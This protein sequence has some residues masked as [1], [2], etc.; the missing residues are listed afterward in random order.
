MP[1]TQ[2]ISKSKLLNVLERVIDEIDDWLIIGDAEGKIVYAN[3]NV[4]TSCGCT[5]T[6]ILGQD[7][8]MF[9]GVDLADDTVL[10]KIRK[11]VME[12]EKF[13]FVTNRFI[14]NEKRIYLTNSFNAVWSEKKLEYYVCI[15]KDI[16]RTQRMKEEVY[17]VSYIDYLTNFP[18][19][20]VFLESLHKQVQRSRKNSY[21]FTVIL[22]DIKKIGEIN[23]TYG[24]GVGDKIIKEVG[25]RIKS[26][27]N[28]DQEIFKYTD[29]TFAVIHQN[30]KD[31]E[32]TKK[33]LET[34]NEVMQ[35][36]I[37]IH[38]SYMYMA[39]KAGVVLYPEN[40]TSPGE[41]VKMVQIALAKA[42][43]EISYSSYVFYTKDIQEE[44][45]NNMLLESDMR[46]AVENDEFLVYYQPF[47]DLNSN[48]IVGM[49]ALI[50]RLMGNGELVLPGKFIGLLEKMNLIEKVGIMVIEKVCVQIRK[51]IDRGYEIVPISVNLSALQ[52][53]NP[54]LAKNIKN[55]LNRYEIE[56]QYI[57]LEIT[58]STVMEDVGIAQLVIHELKSYGFTISIDDF[59]TGYASIG[60]LK[61]FMFDHLKIDISFIRE[62]VK[63]PQDRTIVEAII[64][65]AKTLNLKTIA[66]GIENEEQLH[67]MSRLGCE[68]GQGFLWNKPISAV[69]I[70]D[71]YFKV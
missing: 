56:P 61:K 12:G 47:V 33:L 8:C 64:S 37:K 3:E 53:K 50:R 1:I 60:Y 43:K 68:M 22:I 15:S 46:I 19:E 40:S 67:I 66:E 28:Q 14:K 44:V 34:L 42:K 23:N 27:L 18:N 69:E 16:T 21:K 54:N 26:Y 10:E 58:E 71:R 30:I 35:E 57:V 36:P 29:N 39:F 13:E 2:E 63:N 52:F 41:L 62:I 55:I 25:H 7:M 20:K 31:I 11:F 17:R 59:G 65:I 49:E 45:Q 5:K 51:W 6:S 48:K 9:V 4:Y 32:E 38:N 24:L 70:E